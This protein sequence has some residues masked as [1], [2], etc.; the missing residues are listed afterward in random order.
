MAA[1]F[2]GAGGSDR[3]SV[4]CLLHDEESLAQGH[5]AAGR[6]CGVSFCG[7]ADADSYSTFESASNVNGI[8]APFALGD[9]C[10]G[11]HVFRDPSLTFRRRKALLMTETELRLIAAPAMIG[12]SSRP[13]NGYSTPAATGI[14][15]AL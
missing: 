11:N 10:F 8:E 5:V 1:F 6:W 14:P 9:R 3:D 15:S 4:A 12:L 2:A 13:K 7:L